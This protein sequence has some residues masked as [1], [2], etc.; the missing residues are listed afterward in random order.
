[1]YLL[2]L[3]KDDAFKDLD[4][5][6]PR[7]RNVPIDF[8]SRITFVDQLLTGI[9]EAK[10]NDIPTYLLLYLKTSQH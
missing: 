6:P 5:V 7:E 3:F 1:M 10:N 2:L 4:I 9:G 8:A